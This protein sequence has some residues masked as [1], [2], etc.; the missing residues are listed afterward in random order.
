MGTNLELALKVNAIVNGI[1]DIQRL[2]N[3]IKTLARDGGKK[4]PDGSAALR[5]GLA[6]T[7]VA[8]N[9]ARGDLD[10]LRDGA[11]K[12][13]D[14]MRDIGQQIGAALSLAVIGNFARSAIKEFAAAEAG[15]KGL[16]AVANHS[17][18]G[19]G[20]A[21]DAAG[22]LAADGLISAQDASKALQNLLARGYR[23]DDAI[24]VITR[25]KD[26]AAFNR[27]AHL[28][29][30]EAVVTATE[31]LKNE[32]SILVD[33]AG[34]T[35]NVSKMWDDY[36]AKLGK[37]TDSLTQAEKIQA[38]VNGVMR[39]TEA[40]AGNAA[41][42]SGGLQGQM[43]KLDTESKKLKASIGELLA[44]AFEDLLMIGQH[45]INDFAKPMVFLFS[46]MGI[47]AARAAKQV[48]TLWD[49][50]TGKTSWKEAGK[51]AREDRLLAEEMMQGVAGRL[52]AGILQ[53]QEG[54]TGGFDAARI[55]ARQ[56][57]LN[58]S[59]KNKKP[60]FSVPDLRKEIDESFRLLQDALK[61]ES[62]AW[63][64]ALDQR[65]IAIA[66]WYK[67]KQRLAEQDFGNSKDRLDK[68]R[69]EQAAHLVK[70][71]ALAARSQGDDR[72]RAEK[73]IHKTKGEVAKIDA[74]LI[75]L[76]RER[77]AVLGKLSAEAAKKEKDYRDAIEET[78]IALLRAQG[79][80]LDAQLA[81]IQKAYQ[82]AKE[83]FA[84]DPNALSLVD[85][86]FDAQTAKAKLDDL[87]R[88]VSEFFSVYAEAERQAAAR[89]ELGLLT[90]TEAEAELQ[91]LRARSIAQVREYIASLEALAAATNDPAL[92]QKIAAAKIQLAQIEGTQSKFVTDLKNAGQSGLS[93]FFSDLASGAKSFG[94]ALRDLVRSFAAAV[95]KMAAEALAAD[96]MGK[97]FK[98]P[99]GGAG[100]GAGGGL[101]A[102]ALGWLVG[103]FHQGG[104]VGTGG[105]TRR[106]NPLVFA[107]APRYHSGGMVGLAA[108]EVPAILQ[109]GEEVLTRDDP[110]HAANAATG[111]GGTRIINVIDPSLVADY[112]TSSAGERSILNILQRN[113]G[114]VRQ[115]LA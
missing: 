25:L 42:A 105:M 3:D 54:K 24:Q 41:K 39:E 8:A 35:K 43:A 74:D 51:R 86:L 37:T 60:T 31:G 63:D 23:L 52:S 6:K 13:A 56:K 20:R 17:G 100:G 57:E 70:L 88:R 77:A 59:A 5:D 14:G 18:E 36:A 64:V 66:D 99:A 10:K 96:I 34:V 50:M 87:Q 2:A 33:N 40:Q 1:K 97:L 95:G 4:I 7:G 69:A 26:A 16:E 21:L 98:S 12:T 71:E 49:V 107:G 106:V 55:A 53:A 27:T 75:I 62:E 85:Q 83:R 67:E 61:R 68:E 89:V 91:G 109:K 22:K 111:G 81:E 101:F 108:N 46:S 65:R 11:Q 90:Q 84:A 80:D 38:E 30:A 44:P 76:A 72:N 94:D 114:A 47:Q 29:M 48:G 113:P 112:M 32:N 102:S 104:I 82:S 79:K 45:V 73:E 103:L 78:R 19:I 93:T 9:A 110:R 15:I 92:I 115:V 28:S 58:A